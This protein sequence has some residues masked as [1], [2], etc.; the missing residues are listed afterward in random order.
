M[1]SGEVPAIPVVWDVETMTTRFS[2]EGH[3]AQVTDGIYS[4]DG[5]RLA[6]SGEDGTVRIWDAATGDSEMVLETGVAMTMPAFS[7]DGTLVASGSFEGPVWVWNLASGEL[8][9]S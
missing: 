1:S 4:K 7:P 2:L 3:T 5:R 9:G 6:T 8:C